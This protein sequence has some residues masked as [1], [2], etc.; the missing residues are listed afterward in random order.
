VERLKVSGLRA[1]LDERQE[2]IGY[3]IREAQLQKV[4]YML[5]V[6]DRE[7][8]EGTIAVRTRTGGDQG[9]K[10]VDAFIAAAADEVRAR[11]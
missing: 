4:P 2:K 3:K 8:A 6:G 11:R 7:A 9:A 5:V 10:D 1:E